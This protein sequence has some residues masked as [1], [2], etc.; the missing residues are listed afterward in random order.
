MAESHS[1]LLISS[2]LHVSVEVK[3]YFE[4]KTQRNKM[5]RSFLNLPSKPVHHTIIFFFHTSLDA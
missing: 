5:E 1:M 4:C 3:G 2:T